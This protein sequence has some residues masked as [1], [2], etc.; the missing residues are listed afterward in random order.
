MKQNQDG[1][2]QLVAVSENFKAVSAAAALT[3][4]DRIVEVVAAS[5]SYALT[6][7]NVSVMAGVRVRIYAK[8]IGSGY[9]VTIQDGDE[10][11]GWKDIVLDHAKQYVVLESDGY[12]WRVV[13]SNVAGNYTSPGMVES[14]SGH[15]QSTGIAGAAAVG[16]T[17]T[18]NLFRTSDGNMFVYH[19]KGTQTILGPG[20]GT[21][22]LN[23]GMDQTDNDGVEIVP[24]GI[25]SLSPTAFVVGSGAFYARLKAK[26]AVVA[27]TDDFLFG[28][29][30]AEAFQAN[31]DDY[32]EMA[33]F[34]LIAGDLNIETILNGAGTTTTDTT[35]D[36][37]DTEY[38]DLEV[39]V[40]KS[41]AVTYKLFG[42]AP[43][44]VAAFT[45]DA[46]EVVVPFIFLLQANAA[47]TGVL[48]LTDFE[49]GYL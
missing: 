6:L 39:H 13:R 24:N 41:G 32:D 30:K 25:T 7:A 1:L 27:G 11:A 45:F 48:D 35:N 15:V 14:F 26:I 31:V 23:I 44:T 29:R 49:C 33:A 18:T 46:G 17:G 16:A 9:A 38:V 5:A 40:A 34:N 8:T 42:D 10:S 28:F 4:A 47:Q 20:L 19:I 21:V 37:A 36:V 3:P 22:G 43:A 2:M 12:A